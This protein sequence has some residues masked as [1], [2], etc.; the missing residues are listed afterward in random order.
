MFERASLKIISAVLSVICVAAVLESSERDTSSRKPSGAHADISHLE[1][2]IHEMVNTERKKNGLA[3]LSWDE[4]LHSIARKHSQDM[5]RRNFFSHDDPEGRSF[6]GRYKD[7][8][9]ECRIV[10]GNTIFGGAENISQLYLGN[11]SLGKDG[12]NFLNDDIVDKVA[13]SVV[14]RWMGSS[15]HRENI[16]TPYFKRHGIGVAVSEDIVYVTEAFC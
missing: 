6:S 9:F 11:S 4:N 14:K 5:A 13:E 7:A 3:P 12:Q 16:L 1:K 10:V 15:N 8:Q 2:K